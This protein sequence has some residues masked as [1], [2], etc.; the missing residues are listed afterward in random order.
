MIV[1]A[2]FPCHGSAEVG[3]DMTAVGGCLENSND[4]A[5]RERLRMKKALN[6]SGDLRAIQHGFCNQLDWALL[7]DP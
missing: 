1:E 2:R 3:N 7:V 4:Q 6:S 5:R